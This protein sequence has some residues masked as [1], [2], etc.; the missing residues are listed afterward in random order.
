VRLGLGAEIEQHGRIGE[1]K[2]AEL[3]VAAAEQAET[4]RKLGC[5]RLEVL[6]TS[7]GRQSADPRQ[8]QETLERA[9]AAPV[10]LLTGEDEGLLAYWGALSCARRLPKSLT[11]CDVGGGSTQV[12]FG[13]PTG[14]AWARSVDLGSLRL[15]RRCLPGDP[16]D[17]RA[18]SGGRAE[19]ER[20]FEGLAPPRAKE[21]IAVGGSAR[22]AARLVG[23][24][25]GERQLRRAA[26]LLARRSRREVATRFRVAPARA[27][28]LLGGV[29]I[30]SE[31]Q[32]RLGL[33]LRLGSGGVREGAA[34]ELL[35]LD[36]LAA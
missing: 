20:Y 26:E 9:A 3:A 35:L 34:A 36:R 27:E 13:T 16:P 1:E 24:E 5:E 22:A 31:I 2:L 18:V 30:L 8:L 6:V 25:L 23:P 32:R 4:A 14:A 19:V 12:I 17:K 21:A 15:T 10:R 29:L 11:V 28:T 33:T 7:P